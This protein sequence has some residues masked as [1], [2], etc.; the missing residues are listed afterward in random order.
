MAE[1]EKAMQTVMTNASMTLSAP[2]HTPHGSSS[3]LSAVR[4]WLD[5]F[6]TCV[7]GRDFAGGRAMFAEDVTSFGTWTG[8]MDG[9]DTLIARQWRNVWPRTCGF[10]FDLENVVGDASSDGGTAWTAATWT[11]HALNDD[12]T[13][14]FLRSGRATFAFRRQHGLLVAVHSHFSLDPAGRL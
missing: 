14:G 1:Q 3:G 6:A 12:G 4:D 11:S 9:L 7:R 2:R 8:R 5:R 10:S 13:P